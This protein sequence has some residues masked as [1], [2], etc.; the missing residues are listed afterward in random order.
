MEISDGGAAASPVDRILG[1]VLENLGDPRVSTV[2]SGAFEAEL[3]AFVSSGFIESFKD[4]VVRLE[5]PFDGFTEGI[6]TAPDPAG[7]A[8]AYVEEQLGQHQPTVAVAVLLLVTD[9]V[10]KNRGRVI[11]M[12]I[13]AGEGPAGDRSGR[14]GSAAAALAAARAG[15]GGIKAA[16]GLADAESLMEELRLKLEALRD[17][18]STQVLD[19]AIV[20]GARPDAEIESRTGVPALTPGGRREDVEDMLVESWMIEMEMH[21]LLAAKVGDEVD[22]TVVVPDDQREFVLDAL[23]AV[24]EAF[25]IRPTPDI[26]LKFGQLRLAKGDVGESRMAAE[27][28]MEMV[29]DEESPIHQQAQAL[30]E[31]VTEASPL[32][33]RDRRCF[34]ATAAMGDGDA[35]EVETLRAFRDDVLMKSSAGRLVVGA[36][37]R[38]SP[39]IADVI[40]GSRPMMALVRHAIVRPLAGLVSG[41]RRGR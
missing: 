20:W 40:A 2:L 17:E 24:Q 37:Y 12:M 26:L 31:A 28:V 38:I 29:D 35:P 36:Y 23:V 4:A 10:V 39:P 19:D 9:F 5:E 30:Y 25:T 14:M 3:K 34:I 16:G 22:G 15:L 11:E 18:L 32:T 41:G 1:G 13:A 21:L 6:M 8:I 33:R 7:A 27:K